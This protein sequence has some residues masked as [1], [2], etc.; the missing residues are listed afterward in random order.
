VKQK[1]IK[2]KNTK[3][4]LKLRLAKIQDLKFVFNLYN[5]NVLEKKFFSLK[6]VSLIEHKIWFK[7]K[8]KEKMFYVCS[9]KERMGYIRFDKTDVKNLTV[10]IAI[11]SRYKRKGYGRNMLIKALGKK[12][13]LNYNVWA[14]VK[15][16]NHT[17]KKFFLNAGFKLVKNNRYMIKN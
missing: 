7:N 5:K 17:S 12:R 3:F 8:I 11:T 16:S 15:K 4:N 14:Y 2:R 13:I 9:L 6:K 1:F 10:S